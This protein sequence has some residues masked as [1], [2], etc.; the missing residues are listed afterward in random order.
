MTF[1]G[2]FT[3]HPDV[4]QNKLN[5]FDATELE[6]QEYKIT[7]EKIVETLQKAS[8][9]EPDFNSLLK[10]HYSLFC[11]IYDFAGQIRTVN[12]S[13]PNM[14]VPFCYADF[15]NNEAERIFSRLKS[16]NY[17][18]NLPKEEFTK[19]LA[20]LSSELNALHPFREGNG[21][22]TRLYLML[23][24]RRNGYLLDF[25]FAPYDRILAADE[26]AF[27]GNLEPLQELY[28]KITIPITEQG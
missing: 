11:D 2:Y 12:I 22:T 10:L 4:L 14:A 6:K 25:A 16:L 15:I 24:A 3:E 17:L 28:Q 13:K 1:D 27:I 26:Q 18:R 19:E 21:R 23:L 8:S 20:W 9:E 7:A 5:I